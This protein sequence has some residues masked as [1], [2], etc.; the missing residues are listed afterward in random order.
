VNIVRIRN[1]RLGERGLKELAEAIPGLVAEAF[2]TSTDTI[3]VLF[4][5][6]HPFDVHGPDNVMA[7]AV[8]VQPESHSL[9][10]V[11]ALKQAP[12]RIKQG[13]LKLENTLGMWSL[14]QVVVPASEY[15]TD[16]LPNER[17]NQS[18]VGHE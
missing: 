1:W 11:E 12:E 8:F 6:S 15:S 14:V 13:I 7:Y 18:R 10:D 4:E 9:E 3:M 5:P 2:S 16:I 17:P